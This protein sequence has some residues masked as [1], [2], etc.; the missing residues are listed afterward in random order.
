MLYEFLRMIFSFIF[1]VIFRYQVTG[2]ENLP[3]QG[4]YILAS[5]HLSLWDPPLIATPVLPHIHYMAKQ[6]LFAIPVFS[7]IIR[8]LGVFPVKRATA[9]RN[10]IRTAVKLLQKG[11]VVGIFPEGTRS[12]TGQLQPPEAGLELIA[13][14]ARVPV[15]PVAI[16]GTN[17]IFKSGS[18]IPRF[19]VY[20]G[21][22]LGLPDKSTP[23]SKN[24]FSN[25]VMKSIQALLDNGH[26][27]N[28]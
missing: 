27:K 17:Q 26:R 11:A 18:L 6:E 25:E 9:D 7:A 20:F 22:A 3:V 13:S 1:S 12:K 2:L 16:I 23:E 4:G 28:Q 5:N 21:E 19:E 15:I 14:L 24:N 10:A 8:E